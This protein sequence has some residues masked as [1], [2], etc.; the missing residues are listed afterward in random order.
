MQNFLISVETSIAQLNCIITGKAIELKMIQNVSVCGYAR[1]TILRKQCLFLSE[2]NN[3]HNP[4]NKTT[5]TV[6]GL[7]LSNRWEHHHPPT[8]TTNSKLHDRG[9]IEPYSENKSYH[10]IWG[11]PKNVFNSTPTPKIPPWGP[12]IEKNDTKMTM[13]SNFNDRIEWIIQ[14]KSCS[15]LWVDYKKVLNLT[16]I[17]KIA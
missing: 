9:W 14:N 1:F 15:A 3:N 13:R 12:K 4:N 11:E 16:P 10:S 6:V 17:S 5:I 8:T 7:R 2:P